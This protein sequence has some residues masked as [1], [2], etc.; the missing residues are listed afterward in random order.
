MGRG[1]TRSTQHYW[2]EIMV[3][4]QISFIDTQIPLRGVVSE[5]HI[6][7]EWG[8]PL[9]YRTFATKDHMVQNPPW[10]RASSLLFHHWDIKTKK[11]EPL[12]LDLPLF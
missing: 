9:R 4:K 8:E 5:E 7:T 2:G 10:W 1:K 3:R 6:Y 12:K 11:P